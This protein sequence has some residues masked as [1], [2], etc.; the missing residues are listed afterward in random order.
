MNTELVN[1]VKVEQCLHIWVRWIPWNYHSGIYKL[2]C[3][4]C[5]YIFP[6]ENYFS[7]PPF[8]IFRRLSEVMV[9]A[10]SIMVKEFD[11]EVH[12]DG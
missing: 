11:C 12:A 9:K 7:E 2:S 10:I 8:A 3:C 5:G 4:D 6:E 1:E